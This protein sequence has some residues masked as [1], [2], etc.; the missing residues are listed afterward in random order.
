VILGVDGGG[1]KTEAWLA[2]LN[3]S[4][5]PVVIGR[6]RSGSSNP[7]AVGMDAALEHLDQAVDWAWTDAG[8]RERPVDVAVLA[9]SGVGHISAQEKVRVWAEAR[10]LTHQLL[11]KHDA[12]P[13]LAE[14]TPAGWGVAL[15]VGTG[16]AAIGRDATG[17]QKVVGG[18][19]Y[20]YGDEGSAYWIGRCALEALARAAD[21]RG[22]P[23]KLSA[24]ILARLQAD[25]PRSALPAL[26]ATGNVRGAIA[27]LAEAVEATAQAG[28]AIASRIVD[29]AAHE[30]ASMVEVLR[31]ELDFGSD[32][33]LALA[34]GVVCGSSLLRERLLTKL[35]ELS[36][37]P[38]PVRIVPQ[39]VAGCLKIAMQ[40][41]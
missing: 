6:S 38:E 21:G 4:G 35:S 12:D 5:E 37:H 24:A 17:N 41:L 29:D 34:G 31:R 3:E 7:R 20:H 27:S 32:F 2:H 10:K 8:Y 40:S 15:I 33:P 26:E 39:P 25:E 28:D 30:L 16:S 14:G 13:V 9:M 22:Q 19:G 36:L 11:L 18:W 23:T 1:T